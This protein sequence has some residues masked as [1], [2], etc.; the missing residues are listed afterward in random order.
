MA[1]GGALPFCGRRAQGRQCILFCF[2]S[3]LSQASSH[4]AAGDETGVRR[5][6]P[7]SKPEP[8]QSMRTVRQDG[9]SVPTEESA[10]T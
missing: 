2:V 4:H 1:G 10:D 3:I 6:L 8:G 5:Q 9:K 7:G